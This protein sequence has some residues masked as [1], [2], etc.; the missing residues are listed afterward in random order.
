MQSSVSVIV[1]L[2][3]S[4]ELTHITWCVTLLW[5][6]FKFQNTD[7]HRRWFITNKWQTLLKDLLSLCWSL[8]HISFIWADPL[9]LSL[10]LYKDPLSPTST[11]SL[12]QSVLQMIHWINHSC[13]DLWTFS[14]VMVKGPDRDIPQIQDLHCPTRT[15]TVSVV[16]IVTIDVLVDISLT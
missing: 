13:S 8:P 1:V 16:S 4:S 15:H 6:N 11:H 12:A 7:T 5:A 3:I 14:V 9:S 10:P 2:I